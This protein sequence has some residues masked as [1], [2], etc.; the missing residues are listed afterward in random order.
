MQYDTTKLFEEAIPL[1]AEDLKAAR[2]G[3]GITSARA[4]KRA[5]ISWSRYR[6]LETGQVRVSQRG[7]AKMVEAAR[8]LGLAS[9]R[10]SYV[11]II[12]QYVRAGV[13]KD[14]PPTI[15]FDALDSPITEL[16]ARGHFI[17]PHLV[18]DFLD[19]VG[20]TPVLDSRKQ[21][22]KMMVELWV[23]A[24]YALSL[25]DDYE[26][27]VRPI[28]DD[29]PDTEVLIVDRKSN[30][31]NVRKVEI[32][33]YGRYS[34]ELTDVIANKLRKRYEKGTVLL[35][36]VEEAQEIL[37]AQLYRF[38]QRHNPHRQEIVIIGGADEAGEFRVSPWLWEVK[39]A[40]GEVAGIEVTTVMRENNKA[41][42]RFDGAV[43]EPPF[44]RRLRPKGP[45]FVKSVAL[46][47]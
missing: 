25:R 30:G 40:P 5:G 39:P 27:Y 26:Y 18:L 43:A 4:A 37:A 17:S 34:A 32:T 13:A 20:I 2:T 28:S 24:I 42:C 38:I 45:V 6:T 46:H 10:L 16:R 8:S 47:R 9:V 21:I 15:F 41:R 1:I 3:L 23:T 35:V 44:M 31:T 29:P 14:E 33:R 11:D 7:V 22:D 19:R 12:N 36:L